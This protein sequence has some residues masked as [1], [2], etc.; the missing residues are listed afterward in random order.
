MVETASR[1]NTD[2]ENRKLENA[3]ADLSPVS[4][5]SLVSNLIGMTF[6]VNIQSD[7]RNVH[8]ESAS[9]EKSKS[10]LAYFVIPVGFFVLKNY[11]N[12]FTGTVFLWQ[13]NC[14]K[15]VLGF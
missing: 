9:S 13:Y 4:F 2:F 8:W 15:F 10:L 7:I 3:D 12:V 1:Y 5:L 11:L 14:L 6:V